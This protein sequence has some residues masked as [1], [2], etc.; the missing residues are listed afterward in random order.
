VDAIKKHEERVA[1]PKKD[2]RKA[3]AVI[4]KTPQGDLF[5]E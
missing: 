1:R 2:L 3:Y 4:Y 5:P